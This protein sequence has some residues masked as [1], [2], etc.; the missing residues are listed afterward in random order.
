[1]S[2][3]ASSS[4]SYWDERQKKDEKKSPFLIASIVVLVVVVSA[5]AIIQNKRNDSSH[6]L[7]QRRTH[8]QTNETHWEECESRVN[9]KQE[10][11][12]ICLPERNSIQ[13]K[14]M[15]PACLKGC[16][17]AHVASTA[18]S[19]RGKVSSEE[20]LFKEIGGLAYVHCS[21]FQLVN[22]KPEVFATCRKYHRAGTKRGFRMGI[23]AMKEVLDEEWLEMKDELN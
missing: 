10:C 13:R 23:A 22:P 20:D 18:L 11:T 15:H 6:I 8:D 1:M 16:Q 3:Y 19:C 12:S 21:K 5:G 7:T 17:D 2:M 4:N 14:T 9:S